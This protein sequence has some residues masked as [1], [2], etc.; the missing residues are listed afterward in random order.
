[1]PFLLGPRRRVGQ[2]PTEAEA[3]EAEAPAEAE[4]A[5]AEAPSKTTA[6]RVVRASYLGPVEPRPK[7]RASKR[8]NQAF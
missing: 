8:L 2:A 5:G 6:P 1:M 7:P 3:A 4:A